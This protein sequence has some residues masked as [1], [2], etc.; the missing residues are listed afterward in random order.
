MLMGSLTQQARDVARNSGDE[1]ATMG[2][3]HPPIMKT[4]PRTLAA[5]LTLASVSVGY[6]TGCSKTSTRQSTGEI[7]DD[8][9]VT[10]KVKAE[11]VK[12]PLVKAMDIKVNTFKGTVQLSGFADSAEE[13]KRAE[14][15]ARGVP[16]V[17]K[18]ENKIELKTK[19]AP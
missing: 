9:A 7:V 17:N 6:L 16:G 15:L 11:F 3:H 8:T 1:I 14:E 10:S 2:Y 18:I 19:V 5:I 13:K 4:S 12:D